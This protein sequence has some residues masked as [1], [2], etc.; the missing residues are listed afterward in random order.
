MQVWRA[1]GPNT[2]NPAEIFTGDALRRYYELPPQALAAAEDG[3]L[4]HAERLADDLLELA[5]QYP[6][7]WNYG[8]AIH[9]GN[10]ALGL[11]A[12][13][14]D[15]LEEARAALLRAGETPGSPQL[16]TYG[17]DMRLAA[18]LL[19]RGETETVLGYFGLCR[20]F[21]A[22]ESGRLDRWTEAAQAGE[23]PT[24]GAHLGS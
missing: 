20:R 10:L 23:M 9:D 17:P 3:E 8:N 15:D 21:W 24:F 19:E 12:L 7:N 6:N 14:R 16:D 5:A 4:E 1:E 18:A 11:V 13:R 22:G 2:W